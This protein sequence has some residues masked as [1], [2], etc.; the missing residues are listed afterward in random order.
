MY[1]FNL[2]FKFVS[3][4]NE[5]R[6]VFWGVLTSKKFI[7]DTLKSNNM[8]TIIFIYNMSIKSII[9]MRKLNFANDSDRFDWYSL[10]ADPFC[11]CMHKKL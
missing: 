6:W 5:T 4:S 9:F 1:E 2:M 7:L 8:A 3:L 10:I 11:T